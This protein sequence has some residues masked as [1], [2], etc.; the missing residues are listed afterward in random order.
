MA[1][2][3][4]KAVQ[5]LA[6][7]IGLASTVEHENAQHIRVINIKA[8]RAPGRKSQAIPSP[9]SLHG[10]AQSVAKILP[11]RHSNAQNLGLAIV[12]QQ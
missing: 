12:S 6:T 9:A 4:Q 3:F 5:G 10:R 11:P 1:T 7:G 8:H 2:V